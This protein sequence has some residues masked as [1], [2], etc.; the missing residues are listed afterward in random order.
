VAKRKKKNSV[1]GLDLGTQSVK[2]VAM[3]RNGDSLMVTGCAYESVEDPSLYDAAIKGAISSAAGGKLGG[4]KIVIGFSGKSALLQTIVL[5]GDVEDMEAAV[6]EEAEKYIPYDISEAQIDY[7]VFEGDGGL[8][9][10][11]LVAVR[12]QDIE[13]KLEIL[14]SAGVVPA[15]IGVELVAL[16]NALETANLDGSLVGE[17]K[18]AGMVDFGAAKTLIAVSDGE[19]NIFR[20]FPVGGISLTEMIAQRLSCDMAEAERLKLEPGEQMDQVKD[21][22]YPGI[23]D[24]TA[25]IRSCLDAYKGASGGREV[26]QVFIS[27]GLVAF[28]GVAPLIS[29]LIKVEARVFSPFGS[30]D[31]SKADEELIDAHG[32]ELA[33]A[34]GLACHARD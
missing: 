15:Q 27:G 24:I 13:D 19:N 12:Q 10:A 28:P 16:A 17:G 32:H 23:E 34:F 31:A 2:A 11:L 14:F 8:V 5:P 30:V 22:I 21:A 29:R 26:E 7:H 33:V 9:K 20:E 25:E 4:R 1:V 3:S 6:S 18:A